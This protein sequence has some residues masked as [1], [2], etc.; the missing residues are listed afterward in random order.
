MA[1]DLTPAYTK[2]RYHVGT[3][4][5]TMTFACL[6]DGTPTPGVAPNVQPKAAPPVDWRVAVEDLATLL[7]AELPSTGA[8]DL[9]EFW[10]KPTLDSESIFIDALTIGLPGTNPFASLV[11]GEGVLT[12]R[13]AHRGGL[14]LYIMEGAFAE[15]QKLPIPGGADG[16]ANAIANY[17]TGDDGWVV[18][19]NNDYPIVGLYLTTKINDVL[20]DK[21]L[22]GL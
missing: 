22:V 19:R 15:N 18:G 7:A 20:R 5:H 2:I 10:S 6:P 14:K 16:A 3:H 13:T 4:R 9:A 8:I 1:N 12:F 17:L 11:A 21:Y